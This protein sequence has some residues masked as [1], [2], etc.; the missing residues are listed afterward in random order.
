MLRSVHGG[1]PL[2]PPPGW[3]NGGGRAIGL[4]SERSLARCTW[5]QSAAPRGRTLSASVAGRT[6]G[7]LKQVSFENPAYGG[8]EAPVC[9]A[10]E[11]IVH[12]DHADAPELSRRYERS[13]PSEA[14]KRRQQP[15]RP[16]SR[17]KLRTTYPVPHSDWVNMNVAE[18]EIA[19]RWGIEAPVC[20]LDK[21][22][23]QDHRH[24]KPPA[25]FLRNRNQHRYT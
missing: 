25:V 21:E 6:V 23:R 5:T 22:R 4:L 20:N 13:I 12:Q 3:R 14:D 1:E 10:I 9:N 24:G 19:C 2:P 11:R 8:I 18:S 17:S 7:H 16:V 15:I